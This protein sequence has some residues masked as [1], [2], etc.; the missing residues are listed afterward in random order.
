MATFRF[1]TPDDVLQAIDM[2][3][4]PDQRDF[5]RGLGFRDST[6]RLVYEGKFYHAREALCLACFVSTGE[7]PPR[8]LVRG[9]VGTGA[10]HIFGMR[11]FWVDS[12]DLFDIR[13]LN[14]DETHGKRAPYQY[15]L[16]LW[17]IAQAYLG[18]PQFV[19]F[20]EKSKQLRDLLRP[21]AI[22]KTT[23]DPA[24]PWAALDGTK[25]WTVKK[26][27]GVRT[28]DATRLRKDDLSGG[29]T[30]HIYRL[31]Q[32]SNFWAERGGFVG[33]A[34]GV[35]RELINKCDPAYAPLTDELVERLGLIQL[36]S[37]IGLEAQ[38]DDDGTYI[39]DFTPSG[40]PAPA[41]R[42]TRLQ[43]PVLRA[44]IEERSLEV[45]EEHYRKLGGVD[46]ER[47][48]KPY[49]IKVLLDGVERHCEVKGSKL[50]I[51]TVELTI[52]EVK[53]RRTYP[54]VDL[55]VVDGIEVTVDE[56]TGEVRAQGGTPR[57]WTDWHL[58]EEALAP[59][60]YDYTLPVHLE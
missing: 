52:N 28:I 21:F 41:G 8:H 37:R 18:E 15:I 42:S 9:T 11:G 60:R 46:A 39:E 47:V 27:R 12:G 33:A 20:T 44:K 40:S 51:D 17:A 6:D 26:P 57:I 59:K 10:P 19:S 24:M 45:A 22:S 53:H 58:D 55:I 54:Q 3:K 49:D 43:D 29:L 50:V 34:V 36:S 48:G 23:P 56:T 25:Y 13:Y 35:I 1:I 30:D 4:D 2:M 7:L 32:K 5:I 14:V 16:L 38:I 31:A